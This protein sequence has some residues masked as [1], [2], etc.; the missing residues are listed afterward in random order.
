M[1]TNLIKGSKEWAIMKFK[2]GYKVAV[3]TTKW[4]SDEPFE[5]WE[6]FPCVR[7]VEASKYTE[8]WYLYDANIGFFH[9]QY[10]ITTNKER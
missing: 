6:T 8:G 3:K 5:G 10:D 7:A 2:A 1:A 9:P 4:N